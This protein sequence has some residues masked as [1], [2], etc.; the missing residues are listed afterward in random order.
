M[1]RLA[2]ANV[3]IKEIENYLSWAHSMPLPASHIHYL[4]NLKASGFEPKVI[5]DL[6]SCVLQWAKEARRLWPDAT[7]VLFEAMDYTEFLYKEYPLHHMGVLGN[8][9]GKQ[10]KFWQNPMNPAGNS[11]YREVGWQDAHLIFPDDAYVW[12]T[13]QRLDTVVQEKH[14]PKPDLIKIDVQGSEKDIIMGGIE[15]ITHATHLIVEMQH[16]V[17]NENAPLVHET[18]PVIESLG[19]KCIAPKFSDNGYDA[20]YGFQKM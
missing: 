14:F 16:R 20:D 12:K 6:G 4:E 13:M 8:E 11:Y 15:T 7:I 9:D 5:Y 18:L 19:F 3:D 2:N 10:V 1:T 17:Y